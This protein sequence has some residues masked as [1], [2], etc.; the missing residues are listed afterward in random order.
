MSILYICPTLHSLQNIYI[1]ES[2]NDDD[3]SSL[4]NT[5]KM[6]FYRET[7]TFINVHVKNYEFNE[8]SNSKELYNSQFLHDFGDYLKHLT[9]KVIYPP[10]PLNMRKLLNKIIIKMNSNENRRCESCNNNPYRIVCW[11]CLRDICDVC[12]VSHMVYVKI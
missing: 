4:I 9:I 2:F 5:K 8:Y 6:K 3:I 11:V 10:K 7:D 1:S 12:Y